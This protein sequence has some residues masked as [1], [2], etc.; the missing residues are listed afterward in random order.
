MSPPLK[1]PED[2]L[3]PNPNKYENFLRINSKLP[4]KAVEIKMSAP[5]IGNTIQE[6][7]RD[8]K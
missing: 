8:F 6:S 7:R 1:E 5:T 3:V 2:K 4:E